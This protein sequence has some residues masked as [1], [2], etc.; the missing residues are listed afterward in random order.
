MCA[1]VSALP[2][3]ENFNPTRAEVSVEFIKTIPL[4]IAGEPLAGVSCSP[5]NCAK[6]RFCGIDDPAASLSLIVSVA[7][8]GVFKVAPV[9]SLNVTV[10]VSFDSANASS[11][12][13]TVIVLVVWPEVKVRVPV[14][15]V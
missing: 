7:V 2:R 10:S 9:G 3:P 1:A 15:T 14:E 13:G 8:L 4:P 11:T 5:L 6:Y 12:I